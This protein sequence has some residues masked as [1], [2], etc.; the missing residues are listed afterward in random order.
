MSERVC[1]ARS[2]SNG[3]TI[4][5]FAAR[6]GEPVRTRLSDGRRRRARSQAAAERARGPAD[7]MALLRDAAG[8]S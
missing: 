2:I 3:L 6:H 5:D 1:G 8:L 7:L 4:P